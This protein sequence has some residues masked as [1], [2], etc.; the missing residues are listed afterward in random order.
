MVGLLQVRDRY[1]RALRGVRLSVTPRCNYKCLFCH[2]EGI[3]FNRSRKE[4]KPE[5]FEMLA[6]AFSRLGASEFKI[7]GRRAS[8]KGRHS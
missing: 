1:G 4:L 2:L 3:E 5:H 8:G 6:K 7:T